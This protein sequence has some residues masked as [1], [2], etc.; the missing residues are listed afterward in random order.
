MHNINMPKINAEM[1][2]SDIIVPT[3]DLV[4]GSFLVHLLATNKKKVK[5]N[6]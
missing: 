6:S 3:M 5:T 4:R 1:R 2:Y